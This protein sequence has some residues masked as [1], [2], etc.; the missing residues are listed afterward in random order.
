MS[1][2]TDLAK[3]LQTLKPKL[4]V[5]DYVF[6]S[7]KDLSKFD[8]NEILMMFREEEGCT[9]IL[10]KDLADDLK[11]EYSFVS[12]WITLT[13]HSSLQAVGL[14]AVFS[15]ALAEKGISCNVVAG[16]FHD[17]IFV[18]K[19]DAEHAIQILNNLF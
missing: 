17:H 15:K 3:L 14:T 1:G 5:G 4:N 2:E 11:L 12:A 8:I 10:R 19:S 16:Y 9:V 6:C 13:I 18:E 7:I